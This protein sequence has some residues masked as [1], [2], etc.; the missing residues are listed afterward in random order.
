MAL[1][2]VMRL[3][4]VRLLPKLPPKLHLKLKPLLDTPLMEIIRAQVRT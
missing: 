3:K 2:S 1:I 4:S